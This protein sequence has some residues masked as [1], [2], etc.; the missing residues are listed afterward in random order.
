MESTVTV[1]AS[2]QPSPGPPEVLTIGVA[3][4][5][6]GE[7]SARPPAGQV[8][9]PEEREVIQA[10]AGQ[11]GLA[12]ESMRM[13][14]QARE[15]ELKAEADQL[16]AALFSSVTHDV[17]TPLASITASVTS[18]LH[19]DG[20]FSEVSTAEHLETI[21]EEALRLDRLL[22]NLLDL[23]RLRA[24]ALVP[25]KVSLA[26]D[27]VIE[28]VVARAKRHDA[29]R[30]IRINIRDELP[31]VDA[32]VVQ[33]DQ[34]L[35]NLVENAA[36]FSP[37]GTAITI[38]AVGGPHVVRVS[39]ADEGSG[40]PRDLRMRIFEPFERG[41]DK[42]SGTGLGLAIARAVATAHDGRIWVTGAPMG[43]AM[44]VFELPVRIGARTES[45]GVRAPIAR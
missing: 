41:D 15:A 31:E 10:F 21:R 30:E 40:I 1:E 2:D 42:T 23:S 8:I 9:D 14:D 34:L 3:G 45:D 43:G 44:F 37:P 27:E 20:T 5:A 28:K 38:S 24:G 12:L 33:I 36:K 32:D 19:G 29:G 26:I 25:K 17:K 13:A 18:L 6:L 4:R 11:L 39:V 22:G 7:I 16:R 35:T